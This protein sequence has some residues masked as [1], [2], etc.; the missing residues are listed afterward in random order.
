M[1]T[2]NLATINFLSQHV[3]DLLPGSAGQA[4]ISDIGGANF[5]I[6]IGC[7]AFQNGWCMV[8]LFDDNMATATSFFGLDLA[9]PFG[10]LFF[11]CCSS[12]GILAAA[13]IGCFLAPTNSS[14][15]AVGQNELNGARALL[16]L[17]LHVKLS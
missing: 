5:V 13:N 9:V 11:I 10:V 4:G 6:V 8:I 16:H 17:M 2:H 12:S 14:F 3:F 1:A 7:I 15:L